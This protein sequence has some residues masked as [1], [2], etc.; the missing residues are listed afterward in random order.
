[1]GVDD[2]STAA[3][4]IVVVWIGDVGGGLFVGGGHCFMMGYKEHGC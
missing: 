1:M 2:T 4:D 3:E